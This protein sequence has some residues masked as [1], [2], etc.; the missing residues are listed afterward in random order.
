MNNNKDISQIDFSTEELIS[1]SM[2]NLAGSERQRK[3]DAKGKNLQ[4]ACKINQSLSTLGKCLEA[5]KHNSISNIKKMVPLRESKLTKIFAEYF[6]GDQNIIIHIFFG[7]NT[8]KGIMFNYIG[9]LIKL[10]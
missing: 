1:L 9:Q 5:M 4:E 3:T 2:V 7:D 8:K 6:Q 10:N